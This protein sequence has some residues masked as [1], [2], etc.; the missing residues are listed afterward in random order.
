MCRG[1]GVQ[2]LADLG[3]LDGARAMAARVY[4]TQGWWRSGD[5]VTCLYERAPRHAVHFIVVVRGGGCVWRSH[6][7]QVNDGSD[8]QEAVPSEGQD[9]GMGGQERRTAAG[10]GKKRKAAARATTGGEADGWREHSSGRPALRQDGEGGGAG[11]PS[12]RWGTLGESWPGGGRGE[13]DTRRKK[14]DG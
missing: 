12:G 5:R 10:K 8:R 14:E 11:A 1:Q 4:A 7:E 13:G 2:G 3:L 9:A 6:P